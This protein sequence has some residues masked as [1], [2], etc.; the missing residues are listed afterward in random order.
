MDLAR[1]QDLIQSKD[2][3][4]GF[5][6]AFLEAMMQFALFHEHC[7]HLRDKM[8]N[9]YYCGNCIAKWYILS[10][11]EIKEIDDQGRIVIPK[12]WRKSKLKTRKVLLKLRRDNSIEI[13]PFDSLDLTKYFDSAE[14]DVE[15][16]LSDWHSL[17]RELS[18][19]RHAI[20]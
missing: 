18:K 19:K 9:L 3:Q 6:L 1:A 13:V 10:Q 7:H 20:H 2:T 12:V 14:V 16:P 4:P 5:G 17:K 8:V 15:S 11:V